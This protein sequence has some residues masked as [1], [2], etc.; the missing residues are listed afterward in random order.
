MFLYNVFNALFGREPRREIL[1]WQARIAQKLL[2]NIPQ[3]GGW[4]GFIK[5]KPKMSDPKSQRS[6]ESRKDVVDV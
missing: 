1:I 3:A 4:M 2:S 6:F 5:S